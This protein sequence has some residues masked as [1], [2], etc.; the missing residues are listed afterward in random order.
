MIPITRA[1]TLSNYVKTLR[2]IGA[3]V[4]TGLRKA[5]LPTL[6]EELPRA[7]LPYANV[8]KFIA[9]MASAEGIPDLGFRTLSNNFDQVFVRSFSEPVLSAPTLNLALERL[10]VFTRQQTTNISNWTEVSGANARACLLLPLLSKEVPGHELY[11]TRTLKLMEFIIRHYAGANF[12]PTAIWLASSRKDLHFNIERAYPGI[13]VLTS[14]PYGAVEFPAKLLRTLNPG[15]PKPLATFSG[16]VD[17]PQSAKESNILKLVLPAYLR[18]HTPKISLGAD[19]TRQS[20]R[21]L[22]R[23][24]QQEKT[25]FRRIVDDVRCRVAIDYLTNTTK[26]PSLI[27]SLLGYSDETA[28]IRAFKRWTAHTPGE[29]RGY[30]SD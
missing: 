13:P 28:F 18:D 9:N 19:I 12:L 25:S 5:R 16:L 21:T 30:L 6:Y 26:S 1:I 29:Y 7:W 10:P 17:T 14:K 22:Q 24:L 4:D 11:E 27:A 15:D 20:A 2:Q 23:K 8:R 3:P